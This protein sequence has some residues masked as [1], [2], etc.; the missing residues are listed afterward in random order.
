MGILVSDLLYGRYVQ[1]GLELPRITVGTLGEVLDISAHQIVRYVKERFGSTEQALTPDDLMLEFF[2]IVFAA[3][4]WTSHLQPEDQHEVVQIVDFL[5]RTLIQRGAEPMGDAQRQELTAQ[6]L[7]LMAVP[8]P[9]GKPGA[10]GSALLY[11]VTQPLHGLGAGP[12]G[13][14]R[15]RRYLRHVRYHCLA[16]EEQRVF[17]DRKAIGSALGGWYTLELRRSRC[18]SVTAKID[19]YWQVFN[20]LF[21]TP[22]LK[23]DE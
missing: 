17:A 6:F 10:L 9:S 18:A 12:N 15:R 19:T 20:L 16:I 8:R 7:A 3:M 4:K 13:A 14:P 11:S 5:Q 2:R 22:G 21:D 23:V 1:A